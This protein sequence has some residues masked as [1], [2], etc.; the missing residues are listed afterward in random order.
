[1]MLANGEEFVWITYVEFLITTPIILYNI[2]G[3][4]LGFT[5]IDVHCVRPL[6]SNGPSTQLCSDPAGSV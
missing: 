4:A 6:F 1:M 3:M 2:A 5:S